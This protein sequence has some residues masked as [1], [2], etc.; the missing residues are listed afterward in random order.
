MDGAVHSLRPKL[1]ET[2]WRRLIEPND[3]NVLPDWKTMRARFPADSADE[4]KALAKVLEENQALIAALE[5][6]LHE[7]AALLGVAS[8]LTKDVDQAEERTEELKRLLETY[9][10]RNKKLRD[11]LG[12]RPGAV[13]RQP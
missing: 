13:P 10:V 11:E 7:H 1:D 8:K 2:T 4:K 9:K 5:E 12:L 6:Q 3:G